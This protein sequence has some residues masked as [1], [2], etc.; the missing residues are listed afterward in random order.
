M[1]EVT[2]IN[3]NAKKW[4]D[5]ERIITDYKV[6]TGENLANIYIEL[7]NDLSFA[8]SYFPNSKIV[9]YLNDLSTQLHH[10]IYK[11]QPENISRFKQFWLAEI[12]L[13]FS[14]KQKE[15]LAAAIIFI[16]FCF[17]GA[18]SQLNDN[19]FARLILSDEY[20]NMTQTNINQ[21]DPLGVYKSDS[22]LNMFFSITYNNVRVALF[23]FAMGLLTVFGPG[24]ILMKNG[25]MVGVF[26]SFFKVY[27]LL[28]ESLLVIFIHGAIELTSI[29]LAGAAGFVLGNSFIF[30]GSKSRKNAFIDGAKE[31]LKMLVSLIPF[32]VIAGFLE[33]FI[34]RYTNMPKY[35]SITIIVAS[36]ALILG[37]YVVWPLRI[38]LKRKSNYERIEFS[39]T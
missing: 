6:K 15:I 4:E 12:P 21:G 5:Y 35:L 31:G 29:T 18:V 23:C 36:F 19:S 39:Q 34:T 25:I 16:I 11:N 3:K 8:Q 14:Y 20:V 22:Q 38:Y 13:L 9:L 30:P 33:S 7:N 37:Y 26:L 17:F 27:G 32:I 2:F 28:E 24:Y 10:I 1:R